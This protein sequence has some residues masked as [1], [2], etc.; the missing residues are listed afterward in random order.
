MHCAGSQAKIQRAK[1]G[2]A[3]GKLPSRNYSVQVCPISGSFLVVRFV[4]A[5]YLNYLDMYTYSYCFSVV[6]LLSSLSG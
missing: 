1:A 2:K 3:I 6:V 4:S 5:K